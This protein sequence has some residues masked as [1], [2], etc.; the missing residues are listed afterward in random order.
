M[1]LNVGGT[2][3]VLFDDNIFHDP[4]NGE[5]DVTAVLAPNFRIKSDHE[6]YKYTLTGEVEDGSYADHNEDNYTD[7]GVGGKV[8]VILDPTTT[9]SLDGHFRLE[10]IPI[11][12]FVD[13]PGRQ[14]DSP[15]NYRNGGLEA[16][17]KKNWNRIESSIFASDTLLNYDNTTSLTNIR[18]IQ[19]D[20]D[21]NEMQFGGQACYRASANFCPYIAASFNTRNYDEQVDGTLLIPRDSDGFSVMGGVQ[22]AFPAQSVTADVAL[23]YLA[24]NYDAASFE[25][26]STLGF[27]AKV[28]WQA[29]P[30]FRV[31]WNLN[32]SVEETTLLDT[33]SYIQTETVLGGEYQWN[34]SLV[35]DASLGY[36]L[37][38]FQN[39]SLVPDRADGIV[40]GIAQLQYNFPE[41]FG[42]GTRYTYAN[43]RSDDAT[44]EYNSNAVMLYVSARY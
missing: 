36:T 34:E 18:I 16:S 6:T 43:R 17:L 22:A 23:G 7:G 40:K 44:V 21:R 11:G 30:A 33:S 41:G 37:N 13:V 28:E 4:H 27:K 2:A 29:T 5:S 25:D 10:H 15:T 12:A 31:N 8:D 9:L 42:V 1:V 39:G 26:V 20:R 32:R 3:G 19:D 35:A 38:D 14:S 24:Q